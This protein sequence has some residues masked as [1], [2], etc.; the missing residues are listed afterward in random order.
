MNHCGLAPRLEVVRYRVDGS[1]AICAV[2]ESIAGVVLALACAAPVSIAAAEAP[3]ES[4]R[5]GHAGL[6]SVTADLPADIQAKVQASVLGFLSSRAV[7]ETR[8]AGDLGWDCLAASALADAGVADAG[9]KLVAIADRLVAAAIPG[10]QGI[11]GWAYLG[12]SANRCPDGGLDAFG[13][14]TCNLRTT[15]YSFQTGL[16]IACLANAGRTSGRSD[17]L[18]KAQEALN[19]WSGFAVRATPCA[20][21]ISFLYSDHPNDRGRFV[22]NVNIFMGY[23]AAVLGTASANAGDVAI[24]KQVMRADIREREAGNMGYLGMADP[25]WVAKRADASQNIEN[26]AAAMAAL[27]YELGAKLDSPAERSHGRALWQEWAACD[28]KRCRAAD[29]KVWGGDATRCQATLTAT[30][31]MFRKVDPRAD[32]QCREYLARVAVIPSFGI[33]SIVAGGAR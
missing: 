9:K 7:I 19:Y 18:A 29:C 2:R 28:N 17:L 8:D 5:D 16:G 3:K 25:Q 20:D 21:C 12:G 13:D 6:V 15:T 14:G 33:W 32:A 24:A 26:H 1:R 23:G 30:H 27:I 31:C 22:R 4:P 11:A 10:R